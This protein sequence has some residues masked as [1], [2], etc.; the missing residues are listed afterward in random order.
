MLCAYMIIILRDGEGKKLYKYEAN[1]SY[2]LNCFQRKIVRM[3]GVPFIK[4]CTER[5]KRSD[6]DSRFN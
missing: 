6:L 1:D 2:S 5:K 3:F 4:M